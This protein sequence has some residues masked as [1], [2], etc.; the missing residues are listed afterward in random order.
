MG[1][2]QLD[3]VERRF[4]RIAEQFIHVFI[5][6]PQISQRLLAVNVARVLTNPR[7][8]PK[9]ARSKRGRRFEC[10]LSAAR[11][12]IV[13]GKVF[14]WLLV[15]GYFMGFHRVL[16]SLTLNHWFLHAQDNFWM[17]LEF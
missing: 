13:L 3:G 14:I 5:Q 8:D 12:A 2:C 6:H 9:P 16:N 1:P 11:I 4:A 15:T 7:N 17:I 10:S